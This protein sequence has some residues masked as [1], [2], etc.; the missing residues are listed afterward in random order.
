MMS[1]LVFR[2]T[3]NSQVMP[4]NLVWDANQRNA[5]NSRQSP[6]FLGDVHC[7]ASPFASSAH[8]LWDNVVDVNGRFSRSECTCRVIHGSKYAI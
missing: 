3:R 1:I 5:S 4:V 8:F 2:S 6:E 7:G